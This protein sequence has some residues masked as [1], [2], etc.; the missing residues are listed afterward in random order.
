MPAEEN[1]MK[2]FIITTI[3]STILFSKTFRILDENQNPISNAHIFRNGYV[4]IS[5]SDGFFF[6]NDK[7]LDYTIS[8]IAFQDQTLNFLPGKKIERRCFFALIQHFP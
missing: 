2:N 5:D 3:I 7:C 8:H 6:I 4:T 1:M